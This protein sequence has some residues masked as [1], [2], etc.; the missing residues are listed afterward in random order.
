MEPSYIFF[1]ENKMEKNLFRSSV[2][3]KKEAHLAK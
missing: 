3:I 1:L 2:L